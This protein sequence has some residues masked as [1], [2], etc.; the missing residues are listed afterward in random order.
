[1]LYYFGLEQIPEFFERAKKSYELLPNTTLVCGDFLNSSSPSV[2]IILKSGLM[3]Y[4]L[5]SSG[6]IHD[7]I[8]S[9]V[10]SCKIALPLNLLCSI[11]QND[12]LVPYDPNT[13]YAYCQLL[14]DNWR[15]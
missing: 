2:D 12:Y 5:T 13:I 1:M 14:T 11:R 10:S 8:R 3:N 6:F 7:A 15:W 9:L 4:D